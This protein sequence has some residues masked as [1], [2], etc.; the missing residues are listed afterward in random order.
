MY[1]YINIFK[2]VSYLFLVAV[3]LGKALMLMRFKI[4]V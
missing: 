4:M 1:I 3:N 2:H